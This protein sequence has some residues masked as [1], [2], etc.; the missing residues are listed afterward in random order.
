ML[1]WTPVLVGR[2]YDA[3]AA[4][5]AGRAQEV[6]ET[7][8]WWWIAT[9]IGF[10]SVSQFKLDH[11]IFPATPALC[12]LCARA[13]TDARIAPADPHHRG[14]R[15]GFRLMGPLL[16]AGGGALGV[17]MA[18]WALP[19]VAWMV[20]V[21]WIALGVALI[22]GA[23]SRIHRAPWVTA[24][25][26]GLLYAVAVTLVVPLIERQKVVA[27]VARWVA[28]HADRTVRVC[29]YRL[30]RWNNSLLFY[31]ERPVTMTGGLEDFRMFVATAPRFYCVMPE[32]GYDALRMSGIDLP[33]VYRREGLWATSGRSLQR[34][35][36]ALT[37]FVVVGNQ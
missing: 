31:V 8:L 19:F 6:V 26:F 16:I 29:S 22:A 10:F 11:Y 9:V 21:V 33:I 37:P 25:A 24:T 15:L 13:W 30:N 36:A 1:P 5:V 32:S 4:V 12:L 3:C 27:D 18:R 23:P 17:A 35:N 2:L 20:P 7:L 14:V 28:A 34:T